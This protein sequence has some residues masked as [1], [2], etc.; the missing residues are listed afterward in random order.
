MQAVILWRLE[1]LNTRKKSCNLLVDIGETACNDK[2]SIQW[3]YNN[4]KCAMT[5]LQN[6][7]EQVLRELTGERNNS[8]IIIPLSAIERSSQNIRKKLKSQQY[9]QLQ[10]FNWY[11]YFKNVLYNRRIHIFFK[12]TLSVTQDTNMNHKTFLKF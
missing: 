6:N 4:N 12:C 5:K 3:Q 7:M 9:Y 2:N 11:L 1:R 8:T 10:W